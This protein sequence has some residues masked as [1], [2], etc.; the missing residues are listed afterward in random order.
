MQKFLYIICLYIHWT[1]KFLQMI[2][3]D[4]GHPV[5]AYFLRPFLYAEETAPVASGARGPLPVINAPNKY[6][7]ATILIL[8]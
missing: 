4:I 2:W 3:L 8:Y 1:H 7:N 5:S 6:A